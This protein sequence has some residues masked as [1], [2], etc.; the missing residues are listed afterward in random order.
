[1]KVIINRLGICSQY[2]AFRQSLVFY[3]ESLYEMW[4]IGFICSGFNNLRFK[5]ILSVS[6]VLSFDDSTLIYLLIIPASLS[7]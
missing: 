6:V 1:M 2:I 3:A 7:C 5:K 4:Q